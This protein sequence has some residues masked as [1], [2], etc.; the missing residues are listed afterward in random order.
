MACVNV[1]VDQFQHVS[2]TS[3]PAEGTAGPSKEAISPPVPVSS[4]HSHL[5]LS[6]PERFSGESGDVWP[7]F[8]QCELHLEFKADAF[9]SDC[10]KVVYMIFLPIGKS[11]EVGYC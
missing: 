8:S 10:A 11:R 7:F 9:P 1:L 4:Q 3:T 2:F 5:S 6:S